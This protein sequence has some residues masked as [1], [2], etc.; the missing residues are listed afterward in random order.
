MDEISN[1][2]KNNREARKYRITGDDFRG[3]PQGEN[4]LEIRKFP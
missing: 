1:D 3:L 4:A 2:M